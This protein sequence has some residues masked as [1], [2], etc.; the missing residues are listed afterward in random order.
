MDDVN[1]NEIEPHVEEVEMTVDENEE[2]TKWIK[3]SWID[4]QN[5]DNKTRQTLD[6]QKNENSNVQNNVDV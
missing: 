6:V 3:L 4:K 5:V 2:S 1:I